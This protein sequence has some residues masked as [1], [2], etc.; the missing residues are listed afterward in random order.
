M[1]TFGFADPRSTA[2]TQPV[3]LNHTGT[4]A[5]TV[6]RIGTVTMWWVGDDE[7]IL[8][9]TGSAGPS[10]QVPEFRAP[11]TS[12]AVAADGERIALKLRA[13]PDR[14]TLWRIL[15]S[16]LDTWVELACTLTN[17]SLTEAEREALD[18]DGVGAC[19]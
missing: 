19:G 14:P 7:P 8:H 6:G 2:G 16:D 18:L 9:L 5:I 10:R 12:S 17:R 1:D 11:R 3:T 4:V 15:E 13:T